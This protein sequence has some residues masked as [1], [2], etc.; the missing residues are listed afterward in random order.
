MGLNSITTA[1]FICLFHGSKTVC[2][3]ALGSRTRNL[4]G[5][6]DTV[7]AELQTLNDTGY[8]ITFVV[9]DGGSRKRDITAI[10]AFFVDF[11]DCSKDEAMQRLA[12]Q[13]VPPS[14]VVES[15]R[16]MHAYWLLDQ[17]YTGDD[18]LSWFEEVQRGLNGVLGAD[19][20]IKTAERVMRLPG[21]LHHK[22]GQEVF[23]VH[24]R[25]VN[26]RRYAVED[27]AHYR[28][29]GRSEMAATSEAKEDQ[30]GVC[31]STYTYLAPL[32][33]SP[34][35]VIG[36]RDEAIAIL[37]G[38]DLAVHLGVQS[39]CLCPLHADSNP[40]ASVYQSPDGVSLLHC[41]SGCGTKNIIQIEMA[42]KDEGMSEAI[43][44]LMT[45]YQMQFDV[46]SLQSNLVL[47][48]RGVG[49][50]WPKLHL[51]VKHGYLAL[52]LLHKLQ[53]DVFS[54]HGFTDRL[55]RPCVIASRSLLASRF[56]LSVKTIRR[57]LDNAAYFGL[58]EKL[59]DH[60]CPI[61]LL[62]FARTFSSARRPTIWAI[63]VY[64]ETLLDAAEE[65]AVR[66]KSNGETID[67]R[68]SREAQQ[69][70]YGVE[71]G[72]RICPQAGRDLK[73]GHA[74]QSLGAVARSLVAERG[75][76]REAEAMEWLGWNRESQH[77]LAK[78]LRP[79]LI[80]ELKLRRVQLTAEGKASLGITWP[81]Y[82]AIWAPEESTGDEV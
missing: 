40:S 19:L 68:V 10:N 29:L 16:S 30:K 36:S 56:G 41:H 79:S 17:P 28:K 47:L 37:T 44:G 7:E 76:Y 73:L 24:L 14:I 21:F 62:E 74:A 69:R 34:P 1:E 59:S 18:R 26:D 75:Y 6:F 48:N 38:L 43:A 45:K 12:Q 51:R 60:Q 27:L 11:D 70:T 72:R 4:W 77:R 20:R 8:A 22:E 80:L 2:F 54:K 64:D 58:V 63:P 35:S 65:K 55:G 53:V 3:R 42:L 52:R 61:H 50:R 39:Q 66:A 49:D 67:S 9:N 31:I 33:S 23:M 25:E 57:Q 82:P 5:R 81:G 78:Q 13:P 32:C 71:A 46:E 15:R